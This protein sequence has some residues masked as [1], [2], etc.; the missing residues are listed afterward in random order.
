MT[1][2]RTDLAA[3]L[4]TRRDRIS[5]ET[6]GLPP[7]FRR[8]TPG[9]RREEVAQL[10]G[11]G[12]TWY[13]WLEQGRPINVSAQVL[14]A[15]ARTLCLDQAEKLHLYRL[16]DVPSVPPLPADDVAVPPPVQLIL[17]GLAPL[18]AS[19]NN[20]RYDLLAWNDPF[21]CLFPNLVR[22]PVEERNALWQSL[23]C[24]PS[25]SPFVNRDAELPKMVATLRAG[26]GRHG[27]EP[28]WTDFIRRLSDRS[29]EFVRLWAAHDVADNEPRVKL[30]RHPRTDGEIRLHSTGMALT[31]PP[32]TRMVVY[33]PVDEESA[34]RLASLDRSPLF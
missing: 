19:V 31:S 29:S 8:R 10:A 5:P 20:S 28:A 16:A 23:V 15:I 14:D 17:D 26:Y 13:T 11:V 25:N 30:F 27:G 18:A 24:R 1:T 6:V 33:T 34:V 21:E 3:F 22:A 7:G 12:V 32:D 2:R 4:K 9:L